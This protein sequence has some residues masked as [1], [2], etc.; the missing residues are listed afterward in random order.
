MALRVEA[1][2]G[3]KAEGCGAGKVPI[4]AIWPFTVTMRTMMHDDAYYMYNIE[5]THIGIVHNTPRR[6]YSEGKTFTTK[7]AGLNDTIVMRRQKS[8]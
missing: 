4:E 7:G 3:Q 8:V 1:S 5:K 6:Y 2:P